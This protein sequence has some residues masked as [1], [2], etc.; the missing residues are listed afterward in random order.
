MFYF[1]EGYLRKK[2]QVAERLYAY[3]QEFPREVA[4]K[5]LDIS[6]STLTQYLAEITQLF[7]ENYESGNLYNSHSLEK[8][9]MELISRSKKIEALR[10]LFLYPGNPASFYKD[11]LSTSDAS[12]ARLVAT[13]KED[14]E[15]FQVTIIVKNGYRIQSKNELQLC[16]LFTYL[17]LFYFWSRED[18]QKIVAGYKQDETVQQI[19]AYDF[20]PFTY[21]NDGFEQLF[22]QTV[23]LIHV[24]RQCQQKELAPEEFAEVPIERIFHQFEE[25]LAFVND[26]VQQRLSVTMAA[27][28]PDTTP[29]A[30]TR[31]ALLRLASC[32]AFQ[33]TLFP[34][35][36]NTLPLRMMFFDH[37]YRV[38]YPERL[39]SLNNFTI[40]VSECLRIDFTMRNEMVFYYLA[41]DDLLAFHKRKTIHLYV[42]SSIGVRRTNYF[43]DQ[44]KPLLG[45]FKETSTLSIIQ[46]DFSQL[47]SNA[48]LVTTDLL[49]DFPKERQFLVSDF[50][51]AEDYLLLLAWLRKN[52]VIRD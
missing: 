48:Y 8:I 50:V 42:Y 51:S 33:V 32:V 39:D 17:G 23:C 47:P 36:V 29:P 9:A 27:C 14:L 12:F 1:M 30:G 28:F 2:L 44:L 19:L 34:Y 31:D 5:N 16:F 22:F 11:Q 4:M 46:E 20:A 10:L 13:L 25:T 18:L 15:R 41:A 45:Y 37:K 43:Y 52:E 7:T 21:A 35:N 24:L 38:V 49:A 26:R 40:R 3:G 6:N